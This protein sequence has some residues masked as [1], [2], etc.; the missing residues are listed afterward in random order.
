M[1]LRPNFC[2]I[3]LIAAG[4][5]SAAYAT[6]LDDLIKPEAGNSACFSRVYDADHL[7]QHPKQRTKAVAVRLKYD[8]PDQ[9]DVGIA[10]EVGLG[11]T[12]KDDPLPFFAQGGCSWNEHA[13][14][15]ISDRR[16]LKNFTKEAGA[17]CT[18]SARPDVFDVVSAEEG[19]YLIIDRGKDANTLMLYLDEVLT[20]VKQADR[21]KQLE[22]DFGPDDRV[23]L[24][25]RADAKACADVTRALTR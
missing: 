18:M 12:Q 17:D 6:P 3:A 1:R 2:A 14:R 13:N 20:M 4:A 9:P 11:I 7:R 10:L 24:L 23:F 5:A 22:V 16:I 21:A 19:G 8:K 25:H 15:D